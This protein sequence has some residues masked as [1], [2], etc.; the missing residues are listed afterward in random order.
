MTFSEP[1]YTFE[2]IKSTK[3]IWSYE[4]RLLQN[5]LIQVLT[6]HYGNMHVNMRLS[7]VFKLQTLPSHCLVSYWCVFPQIVCL[8]DNYCVLGIYLF[9]YLWL[10]HLSYLSCRSTDAGSSEIGIGLYIVAAKLYQLIQVC[11]VKPEMVVSLFYAS[12]I[13]PQMC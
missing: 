5:Q 3:A 6:S 13:S 1:K 12:S 7:Y 4:P 10:Q 2:Y 11:G 8:L 9:W